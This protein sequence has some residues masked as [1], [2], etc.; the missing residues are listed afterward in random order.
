MLNVIADAR[1]ENRPL[2]IVYT[3]IKKAFPS[4]PYQA[5]HDALRVL[6]INEDFI[7]LITDSQTDFYTMAKG[8][9]GLSSPRKKLVGVHEGDCLSPTLFCLV[10]NMYNKWANDQHIGYK[11]NAPA[12]SSLQSL[13]IATNAYMDDMALFG[14][15]FDDVQNLLKLFERFFILLRHVGL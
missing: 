8:P 7:E 10:I 5:F 13:T 3:D 11:M 14:E 9:T 4:T 1:C 15:S 6:G 12:N 2:H